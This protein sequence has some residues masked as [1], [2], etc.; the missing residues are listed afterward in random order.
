[1]S[2]TWADVARKDFE[3][4]VRSRLLWGLT[5]AFV[6]LVGFFL[7]VAFV[8]QGGEDADALGALS[9]VGQWSL[10]FVPLLALIAGY[11]AVVGERQSGSIRV[12]M[13]YPFSRG[14]VVAGKLVGRSVVIAVTVLFGFAVASGLAL[15]LTG[16]IPILELIQIVGLTV[17]LGTTFTA[18]A[19]GISAATSRRGTAMALAISIF[20]LLFVLW[21]AVAVGLY[22]LANGTRPG[23]SVE[24]WYM[25]VYQANPMH[26][27]RM[28]L[29]SIVDSYVF[30]IVQ[31]GLEDV[32]T[33]EATGEQMRAGER[34]EG[35][36]PFY[37]Q[38][39]FALVTYLVWA[40]LPAAIGYRR[41]Q[42]SDIA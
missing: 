18:L 3:D 1:M 9:F 25:F 13:S 26:A 31:L 19:V 14:A 37:L 40:A 17:L 35:S 16:S 39:W 5:V 33:A 10:F 38:P 30:P 6:A 21:E 4:A 20:F 7:I 15:A 22:Y 23:L 28:A 8:A 2:V 12:L 27:Y 42:S 34:V 29:T 41:F 24:A 32:Q 36:M 11:M